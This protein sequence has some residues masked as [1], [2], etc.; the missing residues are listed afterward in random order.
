MARRNWSLTGKLVGLAVAAGLA[1]Y[2]CSGGGDD[3]VVGAG[4]AVQ[5]ELANPQAPARAVTP[6][7]AAFRVG[8]YSQHEG[9]WSTLVEKVFPRDRSRDQ[10]TLAL[11]G[12]TP[13]QYTLRICYLGSQ[14]QTLHMYQE[15]VVLSGGS[16]RQIVAPDHVAATDFTATLT[17]TAS[18]PFPLRFTP[19]GS[20]YPAGVV[21]D[22]S[23]PFTGTLAS[24]VYGVESPVT[25]QISVTA[26]PGTTIMPPTFTAG[27]AFSQTMLVQGPAMSDLGIEPRS[28]YELT[29]TASSPRPWSLG[30]YVFYNNTSGDV[31][32]S[33]H[34]TNPSFQVTVPGGTPDSEGMYTV[35]KG[36]VLKLTPS[37]TDSQVLTGTVTGNLE[38]YVV[39]GSLTQTVSAPM[40]V[41]VG[42][43][44][45]PQ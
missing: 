39:G 31:R 34:S 35:P 19:E 42:A 29:R 4:L 6:E 33:K 28:G 24:G 40:R 3:L 20:G 5:M 11:T 41:N 45:N 16:V 10:Q 9:S 38:C 36:R 18:S 8:L 30:T 14:G 25:A 22:G 15:N 21:V 37:F 7:I 12:L 32:V 27:P 26:P 44:E 1:V 17:T 13:G 43:P 23:G 2:G